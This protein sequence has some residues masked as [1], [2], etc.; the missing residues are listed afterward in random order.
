[1]RQVTRSPGAASWVRARRSIIG[2]TGIDQAGNRPCHD[3]AVDMLDLDRLP[4]DALD[5]MEDD[6]AGAVGQE[7]GDRFALAAKD[8]PPAAAFDHGR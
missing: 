7:I 4:G 1:M 6:E 8:D 3:P 2:C 5:R